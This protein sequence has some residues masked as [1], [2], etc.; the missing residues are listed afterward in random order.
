MTFKLSSLKCTHNI[1]LT[2]LH[3]I[4]LCSRPNVLKPI[5]QRVAISNQMS[6]L[7][8]QKKKKSDVIFNIIQQ[9]SHLKTKF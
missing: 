8:I 1:C 4:S 7:L 3:C 2:G 9:G 5:F 6:E